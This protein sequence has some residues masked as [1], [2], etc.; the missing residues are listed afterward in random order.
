MKTRELYKNLQRKLR[1]T[2]IQNDTF[3]EHMDAV[4][5][6]RMTFDTWSLPIMEYRNPFTVQ[7]ELYS[8]Y[9]KFSL[10]LKHWK[11]LEGLEFKF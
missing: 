7:K 5:E 8:P 9:R 1:L 6:Y 10:I 3:K 2:G 4:H 11:A